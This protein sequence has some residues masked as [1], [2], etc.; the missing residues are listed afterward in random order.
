MVGLGCVLGSGSMGDLE[1]RQSAGCESV[2][3]ELEE[4]VG[5]GDEFP[6]AGAGGESPAL[7]AAD[8]SGSFDL[9]EDGFDGGCSLRVAP[10]TVGCS[11]PGEHV[12]TD[13]GFACEW[14]R[15]APLP[16]RLFASYE[17]VEASLLV[18]LAEHTCSRH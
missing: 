18:V 2:A 5:R 16:I 12:V 7:E 13:D 8:A 15:E 11:E 4:I 6:F 14:S 17:R 10:T 3:L 9:S 1:R